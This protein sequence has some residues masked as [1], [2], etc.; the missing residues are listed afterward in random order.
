MWSRK[1]A[2]LGSL[3]VAMYLLGLTLR[4]S[5]LVTIAVVIFVFLTWASLFGGHADVASSGRRADE[6]TGE[7][8]VALGSVTALRKL[9]SA[10]IFED[11]ELNITLK[12]QNHSSLAKILD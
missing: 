2:M 5:Q 4:N 8:G 11:G 7:E 9:S 6:W 1:S 10:R 12:M 3:A